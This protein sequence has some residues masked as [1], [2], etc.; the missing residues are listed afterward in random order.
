MRVHAPGSMLGARVRVKRRPLRTVAAKCE[1]DGAQPASSV[2]AR[3]SR[4]SR[5]RRRLTLV[6][7]LARGGG[8]CRRPRAPVPSRPARAQ[9]CCSTRSRESSSSS[10]WS[11]ATARTSPRRRCRPRA[12][13][14][15]VSSRTATRWRAVCGQVPLGENAH[16]AVR[17]AEVVVGT[18]ARALSLARAT[19]CIAC[20]RVARARARARGEHVGT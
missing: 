14:R 6:S 13:W 20:C 11:R 8:R 1:R 9:R 16:A 17:R 4:V 18:V 5:A 19:F 7:S 10:T 12:S 2:R 3:D 15:L